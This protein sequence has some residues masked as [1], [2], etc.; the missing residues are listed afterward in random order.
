[1]KKIRITR[2]NVVKVVK[3][4]A[5]LAAGAA[6]YGVTATCIRANLPLDTMS[7][8]GKAIASVGTFLVASMVAQQGSSYVVEIIDEMLD[9]KAL[10]KAQEPVINV[11][12]NPV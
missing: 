5:G 10:H 9:P 12:N 8:T 6:I 7:K 4:T 1:M 3:V 2:E 11:V